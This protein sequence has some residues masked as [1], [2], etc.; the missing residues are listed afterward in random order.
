MNPATFLR[1]LGLSPGACATPSPRFAPTTAA[2]A[3]TRTAFSGTVQV[4]LVTRGTAPEL[5]LGSLE[6]LGIDTRAHDLR[7]VEDN[8]ESPVLGAWGLGW[9]VWLDGMEVT[10]FTYFQ[11]CGSLKVSPA[12]VE[13]TYGL[14][15]I[16]MS[17]QGVDHFKDI[18]YNDTMTY[19]EM[20]LQN[21]YEMSVYNMEAASVEGWQKRFELADEEANRMLELRL[22]LPPSTSCSRR[23]TRSISSTREAQ[24]ESRSARSSSR[25]C[26]SSARESATL[27]CKAR[28]AR[29]PPRRVRGA[30]DRR[31]RGA[32][33]APTG[34][35]TSSSS[36]AR[37]SSPPRT[38]PRAPSR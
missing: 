6:A 25:A 12:A 18:R 30:G 36:S 33:P 3:T 20:L 2:T 23:R 16:L 19:G 31:A 4:I 38:S 17:L 9:E 14:E 37:R 1:A 29:V 24:W 5:Y 28:G 21:E 22:P 15:R 7:F 11:Q 35:A 26:A 27:W 32:R 34:R 8:W 13:I 10:Q